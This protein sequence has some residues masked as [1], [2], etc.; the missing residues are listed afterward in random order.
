MPGF[1]VPDHFVKQAMS[2]YDVMVAS[3]FL[4]FTI[5]FAIFSASTAARQTM[6]AW[7]RSH[8]ITVYVCMIWGQWLANNIFGFVSFLYLRDVIEAR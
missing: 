1:L 4:G 6:Q 8:R 2:E 3:M 5:A 7:S